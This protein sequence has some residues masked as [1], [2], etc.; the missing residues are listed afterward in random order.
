MLSKPW[1]RILNFH[2]SQNKTSA[3]SITTRRVQNYSATSCLSDK[4]DTVV[5]GGGVVG[6]STAYHLARRG[7]DVLLLEKLEL[8]SGSTWHAAGLITAY[9]PTPNVKR[10]HWDSLTL[11]NQIT[12]ETGQEVGFHRPGSLRLGTSP[13]RMDEFRYTYSRQLH[14]Q[15]PMQIL[16]PDQV[17]EMVP[18]LKMDNIHGGLFTPNE[19]HIDP[20]SLTM[21]IAKGARQRGAR[22]EQNCQVTG[23]EHRNDAGWDVVTSKGTVRANRVINCC[24]FHGREVGQLAGLDLPLV[25]VQHQYLVTKSVPEVQKLSKEI[26]VLRHLEGSFYLRQ[27]RDGLLIGPYESQNSMVQMD[28]WTRDGVPHSF[29]KELYPG[30]L[31]RLAPHLEVAMEAFPC[32]ANAEIQSVVNGPITYTP[33]ILPMVGPTMLPNMWVAVG[34]GYGVV[35]GGGVG[36]YLADWICEGE[37]PYELVEFDPLRYNSW[38]NVDYAIAKT[39]ESY[40][41][42]TALA[43]PHEERLAGRP[44]TR[45]RPLYDLLVSAGAHMG[46]SSGWEIPLWFA[47]PGNTPS[48]KP[49]FFRTNWQQEQIREYEILTQRVGVADLSSFGKFKLTGPDAQKLLDIATAGAV[50][51]AGKTV[52][53]HMLTNTGKV[54][55]ELTVTCLSPEKFLLLTGGGSEL[56]DLRRLKEVARNEK[57]DVKLENVSEELGTLTVAGPRSRELMARLCDQ[58]MDTWRFLETR[59]C[60][61]AGVKCVAIRISY[62]GELG[63]ELYPAMSDMVTLY[64]GII[65][66]GQDLGIGHV[67]TRVINTLRME[68][69]FRAWGHEMN[70]DVTP[71]E[72][73]LMQ[74]VR[75]KK[76]ASFIG[77]EALSDLLK[78]PMATRIVMLS[79]DTNDCD[80]EGDETV[81]MCGKPVGFTT[82]GCFSPALGKGLAMASVPV[83]LSWPGTG[84]QVM[85]AG[86]PRDCEVLSGPPVITQPAR[87]R[88]ASQTA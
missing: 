48:Y 69:G 58:D 46:F 71:I 47:A 85:L 45:P 16:S 60:D 87:E 88:I 6:V 7:R 5:I 50:P 26:P 37:A 56:H 2:I 53:S 15:S 20:Y 61:V 35:H 23:L 62:T 34:F 65:E 76:K 40:G 39:R 55:A 22:M 67:G 32:F 10:V 66:H 59:E 81:L 1:R 21:A 82:S 38:T 70:K 12:E 52:L 17:S 8:T 77:K 11:Y 19:G 80:P 24:G 13:A 83:N 29:G 73:G 18:I 9:H 33:D 14:K 4:A 79:V 30:D 36:Q 68:K 84:V 42:N 43:Y 44:T 64:N 51:K 27:E 31:E 41:Y 25:P 78:K 63:W 3:E 72:S 28:D 74:F 57:L 86:E 49:S 54:Y 75:M